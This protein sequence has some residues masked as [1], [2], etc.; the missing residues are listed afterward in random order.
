M[1]HISYDRSA[2]RN[3]KWNIIVENGFLLLLI[4]LLGLPMRGIREMKD[5]TIASFCIRIKVEE[6]DYHQEL[7]GKRLSVTL[8]FVGLGSPSVCK[9]GACFHC[10]FLWWAY[11]VARA[12]NTSTWGTSSFWL[13]SWN[14][15]DK[16]F[17]PPYKGEKLSKGVKQF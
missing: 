8:P 14:T 15:Q 5:W 13:W 10:A 16:M 4:T 7:G 12:I 1:M 2:V 17:C 9:N 6:D 3:I 11:L